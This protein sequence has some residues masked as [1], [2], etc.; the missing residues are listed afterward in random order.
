MPS[1]TAVVWFAIGVQAMRVALRMP[2][3]ND[4]GWSPDG[5]GRFLSATTELK[6]DL[7]TGEVSS[8]PVAFTFFGLHFPM[9]LS[10]D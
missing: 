4:N 7:Q 1:V 6:L 3:Y 10:G 9:S 5:V 8:P 2:E